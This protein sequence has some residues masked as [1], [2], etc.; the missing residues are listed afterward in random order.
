MRKVTAAI[1]MTIDGNC[2]HTAGI[3]DEELHRH[4]TR[5]L[6]EAGVILYG[7]LTYELMQFWQSFLTKPSGQKAMDDFALAIDKIPKIVFS[8]TLKE[9]GWETAT[10]ATKTIEE[11]LT[12]LKQQ[13]GKDILIGSR[14]LIIYLLNRQLI[15][16]FQV[17][18]HPLLEGRGLQLFE[19]IDTR[20]QFRLSKTKT[21]PS[22]CIVLHY[23]PIR[24]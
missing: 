11:E 3:P 6:D 20:S 14:S 10:I 9:T 5:L 2:D 12:A 7:R 21:F 1:N 17:C 23:E 16:E 4:Y 15:D 24:N 19:K 8:N 22:G 13:P 18:I